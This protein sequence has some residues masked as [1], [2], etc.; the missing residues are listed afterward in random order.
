MSTITFPAPD[1]SAKIDF[2]WS[3]TGDAASGGAFHELLPDSGVH[4]VVRLS[5]SGGKIVLLGLAT[6]KASVELDRGS[7][8]FGIRFH[9][10]QAPRLA[11]VRASELTNGYVELTRM[12]GRTVDSVADELWSLPDAASRQR[13]ME[14]LLRRAAPPLVGDR[15]CRVAALLLE[16]H[17]GSLRVD[18]LA[19]ELGF[20]VRSLE[21]TFREELGVTPKRLIRLVRLRHVLGALHAGR[22][23]TLAE[24]AHA[25]GYSDQPHMIRD[26]KQLTGRAPGEEDAFRA[27]PLES[28]QTRIVH[29][30]D[31]RNPPRP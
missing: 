13:L 20:H 29:R 5:S 27:R 6:E 24:L 10:A 17:G 25:A 23:G 7:Q 28:A 8:Y 2:C 14:D 11:D 30:R 1:L 16:T 19:R 15:R 22:F 4:L 31:R 18:E 3:V 21:R 12:G 26:F 9:T